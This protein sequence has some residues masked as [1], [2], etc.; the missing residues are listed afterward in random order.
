ML[1]EVWL[2]VS[3]FLVFIGLLASDGLLMVVGSLAIVVWLAAQLWD[4]YSFRAV[5]HS[6]SVGRNRAFIGDEIDYA[7]TL[8]NDKLLPLIWVDIQD[9]FPEGLELRGAVMRASVLETDRQHS[10]VTSLLP[11][12]RATW[13]YTLRCQQR[14][15]HRI[16]PAR[17]RSGDIF[18]FTAGEAQHTAVDHVLVYPRVI[19]L[20]HLLFLP[21]HPFGE[22]RG[23]RPIYQDTNRAMGQRDYQSGDPLKHI[24]WKA[25]AR[26]SRLQTKIFEPVVSL[27][28]LIAMNGSTSDHVWQGSNRRLFERA[29][30]AAA[31]AAGLAER[32]GYSYG[33]ISNAVASYSG[34]WLTVPIGGS[35]A[36]LP[37]ML[38]A[39]AMAAPYVVA[40]LP[41][42]F[43]AERGTLPAG[44]TV[45]LVTAAITD[46]IPDQISEMQANGY[47]VTVLYAGDG[48]LPGRIAGVPVISMS[49]EL[50]ADFD[51][52]YPGNAADE[53]E[54]EPVLAK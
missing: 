46:S 5:T 13:K 44:A 4:K 52:T 36:Q 12:Q 43:R 45:L 50:D 26:A 53:G 3:G 32:R 41:E 39:L 9:S 15:Y 22:V 48:S 40:T 6:R 37:L 27:N 51:T 19:D 14:G 2:L 16:G 7:V 24:D 10:I 49:Q 23:R 21:E 28:M 1:S 54:D 31:S 8:N 33:L 42:V 17:L 47:R 20:D 18:G 30:T 34:K 35:S 38:E 11:Y 25:T 29:V